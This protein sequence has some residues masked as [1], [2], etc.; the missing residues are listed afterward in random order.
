M[1]VRRQKQAASLEAKHTGLSMEL[2]ATL[3]RLHEM[4][5]EALAEERNLTVIQLNEH[6]GGV[7]SDSPLNWYPDV[8]QAT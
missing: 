6:R 1:A 4:E 3:Q 5:R 8:E 7:I 2:S